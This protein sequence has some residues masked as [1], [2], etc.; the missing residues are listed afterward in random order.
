ME[1]LKQQYN[2]ILNLMIFKKF[3]LDIYRNIFGYYITD[4]IVINKRG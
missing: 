4:M 2:K 3:F 1:N